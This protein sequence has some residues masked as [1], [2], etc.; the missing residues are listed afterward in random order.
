MKIVKEVIACDVLP[1][2]MFSDRN[3]QLESRHNII[4]NPLGSAVHGKLKLLC[5]TLHLNLFVFETVKTSISLGK[6]SFKK[7]IYFAKKFHK[8]VTPPPRRGF[9]KAFF[10]YILGHLH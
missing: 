5:F 9:M 7:K 8:T 2:V 1:V 10:A 4:A 6:P 3:R